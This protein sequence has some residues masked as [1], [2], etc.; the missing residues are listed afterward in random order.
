MSHNNCGMYSITDENDP[1]TEE[2]K[3]S[4]RKWLQ[5]CRQVST[6]MQV[7]E[8]DQKVFYR[9]FCKEERNLQNSVRIIH[10]TLG[11]KVEGVKNKRSCI[12]QE[13]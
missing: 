2:V 11:Q 13:I 4:K 1:V 7:V 5:I 6:Q 9:N 10:E 12:S 3:R 8:M